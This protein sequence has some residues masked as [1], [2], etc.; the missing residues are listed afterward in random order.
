ML[1]ADLVDQLLSDTA[2]INEQIKNVIDRH[3]EPWGT[4]VTAVEI[5]DITLPRTC[6]APWQRKLRPN[7]SVGR[8][9]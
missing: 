3:T 6:S 2:S 8:R 9:L 1:L 5:K 4:Q 7:A